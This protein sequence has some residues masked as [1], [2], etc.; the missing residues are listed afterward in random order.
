MINDD[1]DPVRFL[2]NFLGNYQS[3][4]KKSEILYGLENY[5]LNINEDDLQKLK[6]N[7][8]RNSKN[9]EEIH[10]EDFRKCWE[11]SKSKDTHITDSNINNKLYYL[12]LEVSQPPTITLKDKKKD[13]ETSLF[14]NKLSPEHISNALKFLSIDI[15]SFLINDVLKDTRFL[16]QQEFKVDHKDHKNISNDEKYEIAA[17]YLVYS[18]DD[19]N[20]KFLTFKE[21]EKLLDGYRKE[22][23]I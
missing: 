9:S 3:S 23:N 22:K 8:E 4:A 1:S 13:K 18:L 16:Q 11:S 7:I 6:Q 2:Y 10:F 21:F 15:E 17:K 5:G 20:D 14:T 19:N 12:L